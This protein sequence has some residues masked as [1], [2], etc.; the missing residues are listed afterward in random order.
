MI[1]Y[2][3]YRREGDSI[4]EGWSEVRLGCLTANVEEKGLTAA[5]T[6]VTVSGT[7]LRQVSHIWR[8][9]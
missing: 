8:V 1:R 9:S 5:T 6:T 4:E 2:D 3:M 7:T